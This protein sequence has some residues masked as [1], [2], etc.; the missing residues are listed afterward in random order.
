[1]IHTFSAKAY[2]SDTIEDWNGSSIVKL[3]DINID[4]VSISNANDSALVLTV[5]GTGDTLTINGYKWNQGG[6]TF[7][8][9]DGTTDT[10]DKDAWTWESELGSSSDDTTATPV[11]EIQQPT[12]LILT[13]KLHSLMLILQKNTP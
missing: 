8:F 11:Q 5:D 4:E 6:Y 12:L 1:M 3:T 13:M 9:A 10:V 2:G 7:E